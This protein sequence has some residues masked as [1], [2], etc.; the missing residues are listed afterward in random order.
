MIY[1]TERRVPATF[2]ELEKLKSARY[3]RTAS[4]ILSKG[5]EDRNVKRTMEQRILSAATDSEFAICLLFDMGVRRPYE[6][7]RSIGGYILLPY[8]TRRCTNKGASL[9][10]LEGGFLGVTRGAQ[11]LKKL[12]SAFTGGV[13][14]GDMVEFQI[15]FK[16]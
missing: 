8:M 2:G 10:P 9:L 11:S 3:P 13:E 1:Q 16:C 14:G 12:I 15:T 6:W 4:L 7:E 5:T